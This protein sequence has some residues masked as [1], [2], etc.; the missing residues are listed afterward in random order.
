MEGL[1]FMDANK[2]LSPRQQL[3]VDEFLVDLH[4]TN[5]AIRAGYKP[6]TARFVASQN[7]T[8]PHIAAAVAKGLE[9]K[10]KRVALNAD[11]FAKR[12][13]RIAAA[14]ERKA[15]LV[16]EGEDGAS[17][18][19]LGSKEAADVARAC[20]MDA[21]KL[22]GELVDKR[23]VSL[24]IPHEDRLSAARQRISGEEAVV[25]EHKPEPTTH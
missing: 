15:V 24:T 12:L 7:L 20:S 10:R 4:A 2:P 25:I 21:A 14:A 23:E 19:E 16:T 9:K 6:K 5:A 1:S 13:E 22:L 3:F 17:I 8:K 18:E 11:H